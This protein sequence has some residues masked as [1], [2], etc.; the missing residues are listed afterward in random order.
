[1]TKESCTE[2]WKP[3]PGYEGVY[4]ASNKG[5]IRRDTKNRLMK[6]SINR[7]NGYVYTQLSKNG[8]AKTRRVHVLVMAAFKPVNKRPGYD[9]DFTIDHIDGNKTNNNLDNLEWVTQS[10]NQLRAYALG[11]NGKSTRPVIDLDTLQVFESCSKA[12]LS[13]GSN[14]ATA[15][16]RVC[17]GKRSQYRD[18]HFAYLDDYKSGTIPKFTGRAKESCKK[19][20]R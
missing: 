20:W 3:I 6:L 11:I 5:N 13:V 15:I 12:A 4:S 17:Q 10:E 1:M 8:V 2:I 19:L 9:K 18:H 7:N 14:R 16:V